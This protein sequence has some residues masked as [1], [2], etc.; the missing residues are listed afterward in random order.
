MLPSL[1]CMLK[2][3]GVWF[4]KSARILEIW[5]PNSR[6]WSPESA[7]VTALALLCPVLQKQVVQ[8]DTSGIDPVENAGYCP[9]YAKP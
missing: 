2:K 6:V 3:F 8:K 4:L 9:S 5:C 7:A 1:F